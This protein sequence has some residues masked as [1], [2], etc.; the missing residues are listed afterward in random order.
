MLKWIGGIIYVHIYTGDSV[1]VFMVF[2]LGRVNNWK[3]LA[4]HG[5]CF[6]PI[7][8]LFAWK[9]PKASFMAMWCAVCVHSFLSLSL[10]LC[11]CVRSLDGQLEN[12]VD[13]FTSRQ[14]S[15]FFSFVFFFS[16]CTRKYKE[17]DRERESAENDVV[18]CH[19]R[20]L[21]YSV[22]PHRSYIYKNQWCH[23]L[24]SFYRINF[25]GDS[26]NNIRCRYHFIHFYLCSFQRCC[27]FFR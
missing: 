16:L 9:L 6:C 20:G 8:N 19:W 15:F 21:D 22:A 2:F 27:F 13:W 11:V 17:E 12:R 25:Y 1:T 7:A 23:I 3:Q 14:S 4:M 18:L 26:I 5:N 24:C 10:S